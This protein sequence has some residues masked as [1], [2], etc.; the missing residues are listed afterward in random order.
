MVEI[1]LKKS[2]RYFIYVF[3]DSSYA[4]ISFEKKTKLGFSFKFD[5]R[6][7]DIVF[8][9]R[10]KDGDTGFVAFAYIQSDQIYN[11]GEVHVH[12]DLNMS[13][14]YCNCTI[15]DLPKKYSIPSVFDL[16]KSDRNNYDK[17]VNFSK[18]IVPEIEMAQM[19]CTEVGKKLFLYF[20]K[21][22]KEHKESI[23]LEQDYS[24]Y[25]DTNTTFSRDDSECGYN[26]ETDDD[27]DHFITPVSV[28][29]CD[30]FNIGI[31][32]DKKIGNILKH[33]KV[34]RKCE[35]IDN[36][37]FNALQRFNECCQFIEVDDEQSDLDFDDIV[38]SYHWDKP[39]VY[40]DTKNKSNI[41]YY[42]KDID[43]VYNNC[44]FFV[45]RF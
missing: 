35:I 19:I 27:E 39:F 32:E 12:K 25:I 16:L 41:F 26:S 21:K 14:F 4:E 36:N 43:S 7:Y 6:N 42:I 20:L 44:G 28:I 37:N 17:S 24:E 30:M 45:G 2:T 10:K 23:E 11:D 40:D 8:I 18:K 38:E 5:I 3:P 29:F 13:K 31:I 1:V 22:R 15:F 33:L 34:C 9:F